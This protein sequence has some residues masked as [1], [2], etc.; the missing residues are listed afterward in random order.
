MELPPNRIEELRV[1]QEVS[2][3][4]LAVLC[5]VGEM[6]IRRWERNESEVADEQKFRLARFLHVEPAFLMGWDRE[7]ITEKAA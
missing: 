3:V 6:T 5:Q 4:E 1:E 7:P 2:R